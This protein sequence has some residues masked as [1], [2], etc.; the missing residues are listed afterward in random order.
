MNMN[1]I[2]RNFVLLT[3]SL[4]SVL[5]VG[6]VDDDEYTDL[7]PRL[8]TIEPV[9]GKPGTTVVITGRNLANVSSVMF[10]DVEAEVTSSGA[11]NLT[12]LVPE[13]AETGNQ[14]VRVSSPN[15]I[16]VVNFEVQGSLE[17]P[18]YVIFNDELHPDWAMWGGWGGASGDLENNEFPMEGAGVRSLKVSW[19]DA[20][21]GFQ[22]HPNAPDPFTLSEYSRLM[23]S[24]RGGEGMAGRKIYVY[25]KDN[26]GVEG[27][28]YQITL[29]EEYVSYS[30]SL[31]ELGNP[32]TIT[33]LN[34]QNEDAGTVIYVDAY[35]LD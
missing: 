21:G 8:A 18:T 24:I 34:F 11:D 13:D 4:L 35:G 7:H 1:T 30:I 2:V 19:A 9:R 6:C 17:M 10:G 12:V 27:T 14:Q 3:L 29:E 31:E 16:S 32:A 23:L 5:V 25:I 20:W 33:E 15:G 28:K 22:L 26:A